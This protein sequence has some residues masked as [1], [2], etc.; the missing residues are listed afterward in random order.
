MK[1]LLSIFFLE[2]IP[3]PLAQY[4]HLKNKNYLS[5]LISV[6]I[7]YLDGFITKG[8]TININNNKAIVST[9]EKI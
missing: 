3:F 6:V 5:V 1:C 4:I 9:Q 2:K 8:R 7:T